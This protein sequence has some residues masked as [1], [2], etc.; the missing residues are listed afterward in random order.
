MPSFHFLQR[1]LLHCTKEH[2]TAQFP[3]LLKSPHLLLGTIHS[4]SSGKPGSLLRPT[5]SSPSQV[6]LLLLSPFP[7]SHRLQYALFHSIID[8][9]QLAHSRYTLCICV[10]G[11]R[12]SFC[13]PKYLHDSCV[14]SMASRNIQ[15]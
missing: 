3:V 1:L 6:L 15:G 11:R 9:Q 8:L 14:W 5:D 10:V 7:P 4:D 12:N 2:L 13:C